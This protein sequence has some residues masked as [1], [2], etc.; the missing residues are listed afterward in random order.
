METK[1]DMDHMLHYLL[2]LSSVLL[3]C[4]TIFGVRCWAELER[5][6]TTRL[7]VLVMVALGCKTGDL[8]WV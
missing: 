3:L 4:D 7:L 6:R 8:G 5:V 2:Y 1:Y